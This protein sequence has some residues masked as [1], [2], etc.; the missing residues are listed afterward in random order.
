MSLF[1]HFRKGLSYY[2][3]AKIWIWI[4]IRIRVISRIRIR[5]KVMRIHNTE[6]KCF[7]SYCSV[8][9]LMCR[10]PRISVYKPHSVPASSNLSRTTKAS[11]LGTPPSHDF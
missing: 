11:T 1:E 6:C 7:T 5:I 8:F 9:R 10:W 4:R 3:D 2:L